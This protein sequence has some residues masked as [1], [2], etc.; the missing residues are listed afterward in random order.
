[1]FDVVLICEGITQD[2]I[3]EIENQ[4]EGNVLILQQEKKI[5]E[6]VSY[7]DFRKSSGK[8]TKIKGIVLEIV[9]IGDLFEVK[10]FCK[11]HTFQIIHSKKVIVNTYDSLQENEIISLY[12]VLWA[13]SVK[14]DGETLRPVTGKNH[15]TVIKNLFFESERVG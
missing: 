11:N 9:K 8:V 12:E 5:E 15:E 14:F 10:I 3:K 2:R 6:S 7:E 1:M 4:Y 13:A